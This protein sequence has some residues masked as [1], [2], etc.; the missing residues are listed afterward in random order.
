M[1]WHVEYELKKIELTKPGLNWYDGIKDILSQCA[2]LRSHWKVNIKVS[3]KQ[4]DSLC[5]I[6]TGCG[7]LIS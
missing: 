4:V 6:G 3:R 5:L 2:G 7:L 1:I